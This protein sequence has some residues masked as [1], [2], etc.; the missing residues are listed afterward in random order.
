MLDVFCNADLP[1]FTK[2]SVMEVKSGTSIDEINLCLFKQLF[3]LIHVRAE[4]TFQL[5]WR[6]CKI[7]CEIFVS[8]HFC[9]ITEGRYPQRLK[10]NI[11]EKK[12]K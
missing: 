4:G 7:S 8:I 3:K 1:L 5:I 10:P 9:I 11:L 12:R 6:I 2:V